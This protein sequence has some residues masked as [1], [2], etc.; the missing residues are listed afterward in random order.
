[1]ANEKSAQSGGGTIDM[2]IPKTYCG[3]VIS[4]NNPTNAMVIVETMTKGEDV[5]QGTGLTYGRDLMYD[6]SG[7]APAGT[8]DSPGSPV[9]SRDTPTS[10]GSPYAG[11]GSF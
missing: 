11:M 4:A 9:P 1:M 3:Q 2:T 6:V 7:S 8:A 10:K 5:L